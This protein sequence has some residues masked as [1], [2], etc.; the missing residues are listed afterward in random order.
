MSLGG[1]L[2][3]RTEANEQVDI[4]GKDINE[5]SYSWRGLVAVENERW[6]GSRRLLGLKREPVTAGSELKE[7]FR[8]G[9]DARRGSQDERGRGRAEQSRAR[10]G[11]E[12]PEECTYVA[13]LALAFCWDLEQSMQCGDG[14][15]ETLARK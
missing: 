1:F 8:W 2:L 15:S 6:M 10:R 13:G 5:E 3:Q 4:R 11:N 7:L 12:V 9:A 14:I